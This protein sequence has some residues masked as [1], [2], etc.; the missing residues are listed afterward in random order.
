[1]D[2]R[3]AT[4]SARLLSSKVLSRTPTEPSPI[5]NWP[6]H[7]TVRADC[8]RFGLAPVASGGPL[9]CIGPFAQVSVT[10]AGTASQSLTSARPSGTQM[11]RRRWNS[12]KAAGVRPISHSLMKWFKLVLL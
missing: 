10:E 5:E 3:S 6:N 4:Y 2:V 9:G 12:Y 8:D 7:R 1:V 11:S